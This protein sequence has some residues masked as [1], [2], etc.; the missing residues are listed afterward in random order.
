[1]SEN[2]SVKNSFFK[3]YFL[4]KLR[5]LKNYTILFAVLNLLAVTGFAAGVLIFVQV[6]VIPLIKNDDLYFGYDP[7]ILAVLFMYMFIALILTTVLMLAVMSA[8]NFRYFNKRSYMDTLGGLPLTVKQR[9]LGDML[10][11][12]ASFG[13]SFVPCSV[14][15]LIL[16]AITDFGILRRAGAYE[17]IDLF[18]GGTDGDYIGMVITILV[19]LLLCYAAAYAISCFVSACCGKV[20]TS[21]LFS[22]ILMGALTVIPSCIGGYIINCT[23]GYDSSAANE[24]IISAAPPFGTLIELMLKL[25][26]SDDIDY[27]VRTPLAAV[28]LLV[29][30]LFGIGSYFAATHRKTERVDRELV[31]NS[32]YY[33][34]PAIITLMACSFSVYVADNQKSYIIPLALIALATCLVMAFLDSR[35]IKKIW[36][37]AAVFAATG[38]FCLGVSLIIRETNGFGLSAHIPS[39][40]SIKSIT[41]YGD[42]VRSIFKDGYVTVESEEGI[43]LVLSE[44]R[45]LI[46]EI[47]DYLAS[48]EIYGGPLYIN[49]EMKN[50]MNVIRRYKN[51][52]W[53]NPPSD[54]PTYKLAEAVSGLPELRSETMFGIFNDPEIPCTGIVYEGMNPNGSLTVPDYSGTDIVINMTLFVKP[55]AYKKFIECYTEDYMKWSGSTDDLI[56]GT[57]QYQYLDKDG[58]PQRYISVIR[59]NFE[60]TLE[61]LRDQSNF[62]DE[63]NID[64][65]NT[66]EFSVMFRDTSASAVTFSI[67]HPELAR[68]FLSYIESEY[69]VSEDDI[70]PYFTVSSSDK[71][72][73]YYTFYIRKENEQAA[74]SALMEA[75]RAELNF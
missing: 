36:K 1:M 45:K 34:I 3:E 28:I 75:I 61:F 23:I 56:I 32:G 13:L 20:G 40:Q 49:Y 58:T 22:L 12:A 29:I 70:S 69:E 5:T 65:D 11:G 53:F 38:A 2:T 50:G 68:E 19:T 57:F 16:A 43:A 67:K 7:Y 30:L 37:G 71:N 66:R 15:A 14:L 6:F 31:F 26:G 46:D 74:L 27:P 63:P 54:D 47:D 4:Y 8:V 24:T 18:L 25:T 9:F 10:S 39:K 35:S 60:K 42:P 33:V 73:N 59:G 48:N 64:F 41:L 72:G 52:N 17:L 51:L 55:S 21:V 62:E 44:H